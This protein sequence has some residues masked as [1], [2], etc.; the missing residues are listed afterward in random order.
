[1]IQNDI[2]KMQKN[3]KNFSC[4]SRDDI[5]CNK[6]TYSSQLSHGIP[7]MIYNDI[8]KNAI[9]PKKNA[10]KY[11]CEY[12]D[13]NAYN[14]F[15][16]NKHLETDKHKKQKNAN[17]TMQPD[18][19]IVIND[20][21]ELFK[22][23]CGKQYKHSTNLYRHN[24]TCIQKQNIETLSVNNAAN[25]TNID[26]KEM[27]LQMVNT[28]AEFKNI[29]IEQSRQINEQSKQLMENTK[30]INEIIPKIGNSNI[31]NN[32]NITNNFNLN[33]FL[34]EKCK[35]AISMDDFIKSIEIT[36][37]NLLFTKSNGLADGITN[38]FIENMNKLSLFERPLHC[39]DMKR[40]TL[41]IKNE[42]WE[43]DE[44]QNKIKEAIRSVSRKQSQNIKK[45]TDN[46]PN[47]MENNQD[48]EDYIHI[49]RETT[50]DINEKE[51]KV[52]KPLC[53]TFFVN[54]EIATRE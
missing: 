3:A 34:N 24:K 44:N 16:F 26:F 12:C 9:L 18:N 5:A 33:V 49:V 37:P 14:K 30:Q 6:Y 29:I 47:F 45:F 43:K 28:N 8:Q 35:N 10:I 31:T 11:R 17:A 48:K 38:I 54:K 32:N 22:C 23:Q 2:Q 52:I 21:D 36:L 27:F 19:G 46:K 42:T 7:S 40:E 51:N 53:K 25:E 1:M 50:Q 15:N 20:V 4:N 13:F 39:T 41:Y